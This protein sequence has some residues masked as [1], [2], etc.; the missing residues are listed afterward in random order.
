MSRARCRLRRL[1]S[2]SRGPRAVNVSRNWGDDDRDTAILHV[3]MDAFF[4]SV[5]IAL[6]PE[7]RGKPVIVGG[8]DRGVVVA[9]SYE[10]RAFGVRSA[11]PMSRAIAMCPRAV[12]IPPTHGRYHEISAEVMGMLADITPQLEVVSIDEAYLDISSV[13]RHWGSAVQIA[14]H[15]RE[16][17]SRRHGLT[18]SVGVANSPVVAKLA[19]THAKPDGLLL[20]PAA[21]TVE[22]L[23]QL[24]VGAIPGVGPRSEAAL[25]DWGI[26]TVAELAH[27]DTEILTRI[28]GSAAARRLKE[29]A[30]NRENWSI[31]P[32]RAEKSIGTET[33]FQTDVHDRQELDRWLLRLADR[34]AARLRKAGV[35]GKVVALKVRTGDFTTFSR[36]RTLPV[37]T[38]DPAVII[39]VIREL[40][41][42]HAPRQGIRLLGVRLEGLSETAST[43]MQLSFDDLGSSHP[44]KAES[45]R[46][47]NLLDQVRERFGKEALKPGSLIESTGRSSQDDE[48]EL[49]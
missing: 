35:V 41:A 5:E 2:V 48:S 28:L 46:V 49:S 47:V 21:A 30:W 26:T 3:D 31:S 11:M 12:V 44:Q 16:Q 20:I 4:A 1:T 19:S 8:R 7:L 36:S 24:P 33:T 22:F 34:T 43:P 40:F 39:P 13:R 9:A 42:Q 29:I 17:V 32:D 27:T 37:P 25:S 6:R 10:A 18:C 45:R 38:D 15:I 23:H 14:R